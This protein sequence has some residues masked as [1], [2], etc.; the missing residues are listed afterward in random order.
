LNFQDSNA[1]MVDVVIG[2]IVAALAAFEVWLAIDHR[3]GAPTDGGIAA[4]Y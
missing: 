1:M 4:Q 3:R 2:A